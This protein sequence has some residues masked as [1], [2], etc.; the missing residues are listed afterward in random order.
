[1]NRGLTET[2]AL[3]D[4]RRVA[5]PPAPA[6]LNMPGPVNI[7]LSTPS[8][9]PGRV[10]IVVGGHGPRS[11]DVAA[12][13]A[14][15]SN[16]Y[17]TRPG[18][19]DVF[20]ALRCTNDQLSECLAIGRDP[21]E[22]TRSVLLDFNPQPSPSTAHDMADVVGRLHD[23]GYEECIAYAWLGGDVSRSTDELLPLSSMSF[24]H[25]EA[26]SVDREVG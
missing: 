3:L 17:G 7:A 12:K 10:P 9:Q 22:I 8:P 24:R 1:M 26:S 20:E 5:V 4:G 13:H 15:R 16:T 23:I 18:D 21:A 11:L 6:L 19:R 14:H 2:L 25:F